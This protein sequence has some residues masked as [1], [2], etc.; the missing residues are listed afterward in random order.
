MIFLNIHY[1]KYNY[2]NKYCIKLILKNITV[3]KIKIN[4]LNINQTT[5]KTQKIDLYY[6]EEQKILIF[7]KKK[8]KSRN[9]MFK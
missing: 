7:N 5:K 6:N 9:G 3:F 1:I 8:K 4:I 2:F